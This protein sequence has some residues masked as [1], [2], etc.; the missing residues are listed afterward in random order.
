MVAQVIEWTQDIDERTEVFDAASVI[1]CA[2]Y[3][4]IEPANGPVSQG[5]CQVCGEVKGF[6]AIMAYLSKPMDLAIIGVI[7]NSPTALSQVISAT[8]YPREEVSCRL[9]VM[10][11]MGFVSHSMKLTNDT[12]EA[13]FCLTPKAREFLRQGSANS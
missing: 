1:P 12:A 7:E 5:G 3:W 11:T 13:T 4:V 6:K 8:G 2:H 10:K 9:L